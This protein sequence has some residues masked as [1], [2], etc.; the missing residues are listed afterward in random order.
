MVGFLQNKNCNKT[1]DSLSG[2]SSTFTNEDTGSEQIEVI[3]PSTETEKTIQILQKERLP[4]EC[5]D[6][7][8]APEIESTPQFSSQVEANGL[9]SDDPGQW[10]EN[11]TTH[12]SR[13]LVERG[14][15][16]LR[17]FSYPLNQ[18]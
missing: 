4:Q 10:P 6:L 12:I 14:P 3:L 1:V 7:N 17:D 2:S 15:V 8:E 16:Q 13:V 11:I 9:P 18:D 5:T